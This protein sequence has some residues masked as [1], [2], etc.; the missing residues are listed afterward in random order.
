MYNFLRYSLLA[1]ILLTVAL[2]SALTAMRMAIHGR[3]VQV[4][5]LIG[6]SPEEA[7]QQALDNGLLVQVENRFYSASI[8]EGRILSQSPEAGT[9]VR[10]GWRV[11]LAESLGPQ[12]VVIPNVVGQSLRSAELSLRR[13]GLE[14]GEVALLALPGLP[15]DQVISQTPAANAVGIANPKVGLLVTPPAEPPE[16]VM[17]SLVGSRISEAVRLLQKAGIKVRQAQPA[18]APSQ[19]TPAS[20]KSSLQP[21]AAPL[22]TLTAPDTAPSSPAPPNTATQGIVVSQTPPPGTKITPGTTVELQVR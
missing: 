14:P 6:L 15:P 16:Y 2:I 22:A 21:E 11:R 18:P 19:L 4:P 10:R 13:R 9:K 7:E 5:R 3:E 1:L 20:S 12:Q 8:P 17:P